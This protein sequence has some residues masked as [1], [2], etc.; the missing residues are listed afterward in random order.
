MT[1][2]HAHFDGKVFVPESEVPI[3]VGTRVEI[4]LQTMGNAE[5]TPFVDVL[6]VVSELNVRFPADPDTPCDLAA[7]HD[8]YLHG[9][10]KDP[11]NHVR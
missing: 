4:P 7:Q 10:S 8:H 11:D 3:P 9:L 6:K 2:I 1:T 5:A